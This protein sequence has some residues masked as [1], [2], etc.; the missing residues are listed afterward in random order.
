MVSGRDFLTTLDTCLEEKCLTLQCKTVFDTYYDLFDGLKDLKG[1]S[2]GF[3]GYSEILVFRIL[4]HWL[5][6]KKC[7][8]FEKK[9]VPNSKVYEFRCKNFE[10]GQSIPIVVN[11]KKRY[12]DIVVKQL[13][14]VLAAAQIKIYV[15]TDTLDKEIALFE[16]LHG[17]NRD[18]KG[19]LVIYDSIGEQLKNNIKRSKGTRSWFNFVILKGNPEVLSE[20][21]NTSLGL[22]RLR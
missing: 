2:N 1:N 15:E 16:D 18:F 17:T 11:K 9:S 7:V 20:K 10:I 5:E 22:N 8:S 6:E 12:P 21:L 13:G 4:Y 3:T 14:R 19:L